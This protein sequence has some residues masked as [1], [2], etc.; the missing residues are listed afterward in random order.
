MLKKKTIVNFIYI[1]AIICCVI[2]VVLSL[3]NNLKS[4]DVYTNSTFTM[5]TFVSQ[6]IYANNAE[7]VSTK[8]FDA[9]Y[10]FE[11]DVS[12]YD[13]N[14]YI[15]KINLNAGRS[16]V[17]VNETTLN[18][19][20]Q[21]ISLSVKNSK[22]FALTLAPLTKLWGVTSQNPTIPT[23]QQINELLPLV[24]DEDILINTDDKT[25]M[26]KNEGQ[27]I[28]L[29]G[30]AKGYA[31]NLAQQI[32]N[33]N[34]VVGA[35]LSIGGNI[36]AYGTKLDGSLF[37]VGFKNP[38]GESENSAIASI[39]M[40]DMVFSVSGGYERYFE[41]DNEAY[42]HILNPQTGK[43]AQTDIVSVGVL[44]TDGTSADFY[45]T[46]LFVAGLEKAITYIENGGTAMVL[47][48]NDNLYVSKDL[49]NSFELVDENFNVIFIEQIN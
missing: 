19:L 5:S 32:Y 38:D 21:S 20:L 26:L 9:M 43:P 1:I 2:I 18:L 35:L 45:S 29:G 30:I 17:S 7:Q 37:R 6:T 13:E 14:S 10:E 11:E 36:Y 48:E 27:G 46:T 4:I 28:D 44:H 16:E 22:E 12:L 42:H 15:Y 23:Q 31:C 47:D 39:T 33:E 34:D 25:V 49:Q 24:N 3:N 40:K 41:Q 8:I